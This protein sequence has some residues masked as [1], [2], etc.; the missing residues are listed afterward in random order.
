MVGR[1][2][3]IES[4]VFAVSV[5]TVAAR[6]EILQSGP[7]F[8]RRIGPGVAATG[9]CRVGLLNKIPARNR[10]GR[11]SGRFLEPAEL[12]G[13]F[14]VVI[15]ASQLAWQGLEVHSDRVNITRRRA[16]RIRR[17]P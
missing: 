17:R 10:G 1:E 4:L 9:D 2:E 11:A 12:S 8:A 15:P 14:K 6:V 16:L 13:R 5:V 3:I 7:R